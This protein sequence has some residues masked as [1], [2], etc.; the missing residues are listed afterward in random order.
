ME[1]LLNIIC[2]FYF[3]TNYIMFPSNLAVTSNSK[4][5]PNTAQANPNQP[6]SSNNSQFANQFISARPAYDYSQEKLPLSRLANCMPHVFEN[7]VNRLHVKDVGAISQVNKAFNKGV[8]TTLRLYKKCDVLSKSLNRH[9]DL[10]TMEILKNFDREKILDDVELKELFKKTRVDLDVKNVNGDNVLI[11]TIKLNQTNERVE[12]VKILLKAGANAE[13]LDF[14]DRPLLHIALLD[15]SFDIP[16][17]LI[18]HGANIEA[19]NDDGQTALIVAS[20]YTTET[21]IEISLYEQVEELLKLGANINAQ[22]NEGNTALHYAALGEDGELVDIL[23]SRRPDLNLKNNQ[24]QSTLDI[25]VDIAERF[26]NV[27]VFERLD[28]P[29]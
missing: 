12:I 24:N 19:T 11:R 26:N 7:I 28:D 6:Q 13:V 14:K 16:N 4:I 25:L 5:L 21:E 10:E 17:L 27:P 3:E 23:L 18:A 8:E 22:D 15:E 29:M 2:P 9:N 1:L 20:A